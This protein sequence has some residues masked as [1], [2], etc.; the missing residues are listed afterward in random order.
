MSPPAA[1]RLHRARTTIITSETRQ[2]MVDVVNQDDGRG[3]TKDANNREYGGVIRDGKV[4][5]LPQGQ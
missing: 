4:V 3:G 5:E 1:T 2:D